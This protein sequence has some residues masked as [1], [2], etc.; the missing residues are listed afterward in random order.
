M[1]NGLVTAT[2]NVLCGSRAFRKFSSPLNFLSFR[3]TK[4]AFIRKAAN[5]TSSQTIVILVKVVVVV[6]VVVVIIS[7]TKNAQ[8]HTRRRLDMNVSLEN[9]SWNSWTSSTI[10][11]PSLSLSFSFYSF[12][13]TSECLSISKPPPP[14]PILI[15]M[16]VRWVLMH[17]C[18]CHCCSCCCCSKSTITTTAPFLVC[19]IYLRLS[20]FFR[21]LIQRQ[22]TE[23][24][25]YIKWKTLNFFFGSNKILSV[26]FG[27]PVLY[28]CARDYGCVG[29]DYGVCDLSIHF[30]L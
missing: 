3:N 6:F 21:F 28:V 22:F 13:W 12:F 2:M 10:R 15:C 9:C 18:C 1:S 29:G 19:P 23:K 30:P 8:T 11:N 17:F 20:R 26:S 25:Y 24:N 4:T 14:P 7:T 27:V 16:L 5:S